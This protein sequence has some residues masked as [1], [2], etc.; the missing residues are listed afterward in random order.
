MHLTE[1]YASGRPLA[2]AYQNVHVLS[3]RNVSTSPKR[4]KKET[5]GN[6]DRAAMVG[7]A[8]ASINAAGVDSALLMYHCVA[9][10]LV[11]FALGLRW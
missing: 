2:Y 7:D 6:T 5:E 10:A 11:V 4:T 1:L 3:V 8:C 9:F